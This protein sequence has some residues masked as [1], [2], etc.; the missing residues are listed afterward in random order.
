M[1]PD[2]CIL[3][4]RLGVGQNLGNKRTGALISNANEDGLEVTNHQDIPMEG[5]HCE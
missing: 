5:Y 2:M 1:W 4:H 3:Y